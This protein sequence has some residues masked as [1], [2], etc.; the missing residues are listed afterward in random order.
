MQTRSITQSG[1]LAQINIST[2]YVILGIFAIIAFILVILVVNN[3]INMPTRKIK[4]VTFTDR[5]VINYNA[6]YLQHSTKSVDGESQFT[7]D[8]K[9]KAQ[10][11]KCFDC[12]VQLAQS[13]AKHAYD[14]TKEK[15]F[16]N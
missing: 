9:W 10:P 1:T 5:P 8:S 2:T 13:G 7:P 14:G 3:A 6:Q 11:S 15:L 4:V 16:N 12:E